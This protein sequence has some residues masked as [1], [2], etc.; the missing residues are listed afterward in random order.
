MLSSCLRRTLHSLS[1]CKQFSIEWQ[2]YKFQ[3]TLV[4]LRLLFFHSLIYKTSVTLI[5]N[6][7]PKWNW[8]ISTN[9]SKTERETYMSNL[10]LWR[11]VMLALCHSWSRFKA[12]NRCI[13]DLK[14]KII[15][16]IYISEIL[17]K[18]TH[19]AYSTKFYY[20]IQYLITS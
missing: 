6:Q 14:H 2:V 19:S 8:I 5:I 10:L 17:T 12:P 20:E 4:F 11:T 1:S 13:W 18:R 9:M 16:L 7:M 15:S 3:N